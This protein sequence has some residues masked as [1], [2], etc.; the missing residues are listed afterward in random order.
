M[1]DEIQHNKGE[2]IIQLVTQSLPA[3]KPQLQKIKMYQEDEICKQIAKYHKTGWPHK[4][5]LLQ[6][7]KPYYTIAA[8]LTVNGWEEIPSPLRVEMLEKLHQ[9]HQGITKCR[10]HA[11]QSIWWPGLSKQLEDSQEL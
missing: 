3:S 11:R 7:I 6:S 9:G 10:G 5:E 8:K 4:S 2:A 1:D